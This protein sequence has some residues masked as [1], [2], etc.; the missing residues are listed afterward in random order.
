[1][2]KMSDDELELNR[3]ANI[4][5][6]AFKVLNNKEDKEFII[7]VAKKHLDNEEAE[8]IESMIFRSKCLLGKLYNKFVP[9]D[10]RYKDPTL[11]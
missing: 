8:V 4:I 7:N 1:M 5:W 11:I 6:D 9:E 10:Q 2:K 3:A